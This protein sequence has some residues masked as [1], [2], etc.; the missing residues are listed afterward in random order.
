MSYLSIIREKL[1]KFLGG[2][3]FGAPGFVTMHVDTY[4]F[5]STLTLYIVDLHQLTGS[6][7]GG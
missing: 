6:L 3:F 5:L 1:A 4:R 2:Y 7:T